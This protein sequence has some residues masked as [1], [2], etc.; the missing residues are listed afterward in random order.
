MNEKLIFFE[1]EK[2]NEYPKRDFNIYLSL[3]ELG[4]INKF[5]NQFETMSEV[6]SALENLLKNGNISVKEEE[7]K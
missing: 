7:K 3:V 1:I 4:K 2:M 6:F 5:F